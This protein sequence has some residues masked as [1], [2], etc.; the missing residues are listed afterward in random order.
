MSLLGWASYSSSLFQTSQIKGGS[1]RNSDV[2]KD[3]GRAG[4]LRLDGGSSTLGARESASGRALLNFRCTSRSR[5]G[6]HGGSAE[7][8]DQAKLKTENHGVK[9][10]W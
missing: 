9:N 10:E 8:A 5:G 2:V 6:V 4:S 7:Q 1:G 3:D